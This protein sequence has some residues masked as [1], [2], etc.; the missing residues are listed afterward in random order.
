MT[1]DPEPISADARHALEQEL[2]DLREERALVASTLKDP[3]EVGD[4]ADQADELQRADQLRRLDARIEN[5]TVRLKQSE[6][7]GPPPEDVVGVGT[8]VTIRFSDDTTQTLHIGEIADS[9][10][11]SLVTSDSP[12]GQALLGHRAGDTVSYDAPDGK[13]TAVVVSLGTPGEKG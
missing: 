5:V 1:G 4:R 7:A 8:T 3:E 10:D 9:R 11:E 12:L 13:A 2:A 6:L